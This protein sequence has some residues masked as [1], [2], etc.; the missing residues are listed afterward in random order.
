GAQRVDLFAPSENVDAFAH[1]LGPIQLTGENVIT[2]EIVTGRW[3]GI[4]GL[5]FYR[6]RARSPLVESRAV[7]ADMVI[8]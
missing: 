3:A 4:D 2:M 5:R 6:G 8:P 1:R 7:L